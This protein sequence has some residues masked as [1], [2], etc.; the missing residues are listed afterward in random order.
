M[1]DKTENERNSY[2]LLF[3]YSIGYRESILKLLPSIEHRKELIF[4]TTFLISHYIE[5]WIKTLGLYYG[6]E[7]YMYDLKGLEL[8]GHD[9]RKLIE[10]EQ[11]I[12]EL[13]ENNVNIADIKEIL[14]IWKY[15]EC[16]TNDE[17]LSISMR[18]PIK[19]VDNKPTIN[20]KLMQTYK[21]LDL[22]E[23]KNNTQSLLVLTEKV[24]LDFYKGSI[25]NINKMVKAFYKN[26]S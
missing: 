6:D 5:L 21:E 12:S 19:I 2:E 22:E 25:E 20:N 23:F 14:E 9:V 13:L 11:G 8:T 16:F 15:F 1:N 18:Y 10:S 24:F 3:D 4:P 26:K 17:Q 7:P